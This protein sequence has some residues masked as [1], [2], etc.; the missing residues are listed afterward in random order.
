MGV[1]FHAKQIDLN[2]DVAIKL[3][4]A[5]LMHDPEIRARFER[6]ALALANLNHKNIGRFYSYGLYQN[7]LPFI[8]MEYVAGKSLRSRLSTAEKLP[9]KRASAII[10]QVADSMSYA[11][12]LGVIHRDLSPNNIV[13]LD[14][15]T[16]DFV[17]VLDFGLAK[18]I[19]PDSKDVQ[20][21]TQTGALMGSIHYI[22]PEL[23]AGQIP[24]ARSDIYSLACIFYE[25]ITG[26]VPHQADNP[27]GLMHKHMTESVLPPSKLTPALPAGLEEVM[28]KGLAKKPENRYQTMQEFISDLD[29]VL[30]E[31]GTQSTAFANTS[32]AIPDKNTGSKQSKPVFFA[33][34]AIG[35]L[36]LLAIVMWFTEAGLKIFSDVLLVWK[37][38]NF[39]LAIL[40]EIIQQERLLG[41]STA[42]SQL[43]KRIY[44]KYYSKKGSIKAFQ[45]ALENSKEVNKLKDASDASYWAWEAIRVLSQMDQHDF[46]KIPQLKEAT[47]YLSD[48]CAAK[49]IQSGSVLLHKIESKSPFMTD[50]QYIPLIKLHT[51][52]M[53]KAKPSLDLVKLL[54]NLAEREIAAK[55]YDLAISDSNEAVTISRKVKPYDYIEALSNNVT[56]YILAGD[57]SQAKNSLEKIREA[58]RSSPELAQIPR[59]LIHYAKS[60]IECGEDSDLLRNKY[61]PSAIVGLTTQPNANDKLMIA[62]D[63]LSFSRQL[64][65]PALARSVI[66]AAKPELDK[67]SFGADEADTWERV[68]T[69]YFEFFRQEKKYTGLAEFANERI[70]LNKNRNRPQWELHWTFRLSDLLK[71]KGEFQNALRIENEALKQFEDAPECEQIVPD[72]YCAHGITY[73]LLHDSSNKRKSFRKSVEMSTTDPKRVQSIRFW[74]GQHDNDPDLNFCREKLSQIDIKKLKSGAELALYHQAK[75]LLFEKSRDIN[76]AQQEFEKA[77][78]ASQRDPNQY[79][80]TLNDY[81]DFCQRQ[82]EGVKGEQL[83]R[84]LINLRPDY[85]SVHTLHLCSMLRLQRKDQEAE[86]LIK[87]WLPQ[88]TG[89][90]TLACYAH[91]MWIYEDRGDWKNGVSTYEQA[92]RYAKKFKML[93]SSEMETLAGSFLNLVM[94][95]NPGLKISKDVVQE[96]I[97]LWQ[98]KGAEKEVLIWRFYLGEL[99]FNREELSR[100]LIIQQDA[101]DKAKSLSQS[102]PAL[103]AAYWRRHG[104][105]MGWS[106]SWPHVE[107]AF[108]HALNLS[109][110]DSGRMKSLSS[111]LLL[112][113]SSNE[114]QKTDKYRNELSELL[115]KNP[116]LIE[117]RMEALAALSASSYRTNPKVADKQK[118]ECIALQGN[119]NA[120]AQQLWELSAWRLDYDLDG[121]LSAA[122]QALSMASGGNNRLNFECRKVMTEAYLRKHDPQKAKEQIGLMLKAADGASNYLK[123][124]IYISATQMYIKLHEPASAEEFS[125]KALQCKIDKT[126]QKPFDDTVRETAHFYK[127]SGY[128]EEA[129]SL[130]K[131]LSERQ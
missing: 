88:T 40:R 50:E 1:V 105:R 71:N 84:E 7:L 5:S 69:D 55:Q 129:K 118:L 64:H 127:V 23:A 52:L 53:R 4:H 95:N 31:R 8:V 48:I 83:Y 63:V 72:C 85:R 58:F 57:F 51:K 11:H 68:L 49:P 97:K 18:I 25:C 108:Q 20:K 124:L 130:L 54:N 102:E 111:L 92:Y 93:D 110:T 2:R 70:R 39:R 34:I 103:L 74:L 47:A 107:A 3:L 46:E 41:A 78:S 80:W 119:R 6:E 96:R 122:Q 117:G 114:K 35:S 109:K 13:L 26:Q 73:D 56:I 104:E 121:S 16:P 60:A 82:R 77:L 120:T 106:K 89:L 76:S 21:L 86:K 32:S 61:L 22:C 29:L 59:T 28:L 99:Y 125:E 44:E 113:V 94:A 17:K 79:Y 67:F 9:W 128:A 116:E 37:P 36:V 101:L 131:R 123:A 42:A 15:P 24:D 90:T 14:E 126:L 30:T 45:F 19:A 75:A 87:D 100:A 33:G 38:D 81:A 12:N 10:R 65:D 62:R 43:Q 66:S 27:I 115:E 98:S 112:A 91:L